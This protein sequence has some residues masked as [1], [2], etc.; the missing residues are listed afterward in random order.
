MLE[1]DTFLLPAEGLNLNIKLNFIFIIHSKIINFVL[2]V[3]TKREEPK[4]KKMYL[5]YG[6]DVL[7]AKR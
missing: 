4:W 3:N 1:F 7:Y 2:R 5:A 6:I